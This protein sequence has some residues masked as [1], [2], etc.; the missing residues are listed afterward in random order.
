MDNLYIAYQSGFF[1]GGFFG[2]GFNEALDGKVQVEGVSGL[3]SGALNAY[4]MG[5]GQAKEGGEMWK[6]E[7]TKFPF[8]LNP[9]LY[10]KNNSWLNVQDA[11]FKSIEDNYD[12]QK[13]READT[14]IQIIYGLTKAASSTVEEVTEYDT[15]IH[16]H[17]NNKNLRT[18]YKGHA[19]VLDNKNLENITDEQIIERVKGSCNLPPIYGHTLKTPE[20]LLYDGGLEADLGGVEHLMKTVKEDAKVAVLIRQ[21]VGSK[22]YKAGIER[23][24]QLA[25]ENGI[26][27]EN[28][29]LLA[30]KKRLSFFPYTTFK[31]PLRKCLEKGRKLGEEFIATPEKFSIAQHQ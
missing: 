25:E 12:V 21:K 22:K 28:V 16:K 29:Y 31:R 8:A 1:T 4:L 17:L 19:E 5:T 27:E 23:L 2:A 24:K 30:P 9:F 26:K 11:A 6:G 18:A 13:F 10:I 14:R 15:W 3:S 20:G 7:V